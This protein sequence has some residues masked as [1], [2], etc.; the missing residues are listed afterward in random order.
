MIP[1]IIHYTWFSGLPFPESVQQCIASWHQHMPDWEYVLWDAE[2]IKTIQSD[3]LQECLQQQKW[4]FAAD[5]VRLY[6]LSQQGGIYLDTDCMVYHSFE[7]FLHHQ[8]FIGREWYVHLDS[9]TTRHFLSSH[10][11]GAVSGHPYIDRCLTYYS[12]RH[13]VRTSDSSLPDNLRFDQTLLPQIQ[14]QLAQQMYGYDPSPCHTGIQNLTFQDTE[15]VVY[16]YPYFDPYDTK[17]QTIVRHLSLGSWYG[18]VAKLPA[19]VSVSQRIS[20]R[21]DFWFRHFLWRHG[22]IVERKR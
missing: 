3:W 6:A 11:F 1:R 9:G 10:C 16:P 8:A 13:F 22:Y 20:Y 17:P 12:D 4:A 21:L 5:F 14:C 19:K 7:S 2:R 15:L 18:K